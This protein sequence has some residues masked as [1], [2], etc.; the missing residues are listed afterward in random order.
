MSRGYGGAVCLAVLGT[1]VA[2]SGASAAEPTTI[3]FVLQ[4]YDYLFYKAENPKHQCPKGFALTNEEQWEAQFPSEAQRK[5][6][7]SRCLLQANRGPNCENVWSS[8]EVMEDPVPFRAVESA[9]SY[10]ANLDG[11]EDGK[12]AANTCAHEQFVSP[13]GHRGIDN[14]YYRFLG[15]D[16]FIQSAVYAPMAAKE[17]TAEY[18][19]N[20]LLLEVKGVDNESKDDS[21][22]VMLYRGKDPLLLDAQGDALPWQT[23][24]I[25]E[26]IP[27]VHLR[28]RIIEGTLI[29]E[30]ADVFFEGLFHERR[31]LIRGM[32]LRLK[33]NGVYAEGL[34]VGYVDVERFW[35]SYSHAAQWGG[36][37]YGV[38]SPSAYRALHALADGYKDPQT[39]KCTALSS[40]RQYKFVRAYLK[41][42]SSEGE[43]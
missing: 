42:S 7:L 31:Q 3:S 33:L 27:A 35:Q 39:G 1:C 16:K 12:E 36:N 6:H 8:P 23:Q 30:P 21:V 14:Q 28:G 25:D 24:R 22:E 10:G 41:H 18:L 34:R 43:S 40:A 38:S 11:N 29:T 13:D 9:Q 15:C 19:F 37:T 4:S 5:S 20:R 26:T 2:A 32:S 17:R